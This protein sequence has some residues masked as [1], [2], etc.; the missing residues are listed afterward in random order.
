MFRP[1]MKVW[2]CIIFEWKKIYC[3]VQIWNI[4]KRKCC[5]SSETANEKSMDERNR[6][7]NL[8]SGFKKCEIY[9]SI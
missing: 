1:L 7:K 2:Y 8:I 4:P 3:I 9:L 6:R 5:S